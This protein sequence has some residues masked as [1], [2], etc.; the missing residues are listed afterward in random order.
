MNAIMIHCL[1]RDD[2]NPGYNLS[3]ITE[4]GVFAS[5]GCEPG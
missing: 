4:H 1:L 3:T 5:R 2:R